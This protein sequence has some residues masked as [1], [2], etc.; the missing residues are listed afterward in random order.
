[1]EGDLRAER[2]EPGPVQHAA[3]VS[4]D[5][6]VAS[7]GDDV[8]VQDFGTTPPLKIATSIVALAGDPSSGIFTVLASDGET[9]IVNTD[10]DSIAA[11][12]IPDSKL[13]ATCI[14]GDHIYEADDNGRLFD[15]SISRNKFSHFESKPGKH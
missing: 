3:I 7:G 13:S 12:R 9:V 15:I 1:M 10:T 11:L 8:L 5:T 2:T 6:W 14:L 4:S